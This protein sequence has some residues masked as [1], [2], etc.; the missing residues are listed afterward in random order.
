MV[1]AVALVSSGLAGCWPVP[2]QNADRTGENA[3]ESAISPADV[4]TPT[5]RW[6]FPA[7]GPTGQ[8]MQDPVVSTGGVHVA[9]GCSLATVDGTA[10]RPVLA[11]GGSA[12]RGGAS[13]A[14][15]PSVND[16][17]RARDVRGAW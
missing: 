3:F 6:A 4:A 5:Q 14:G 13:V 9:S 10:T 15:R 7:A 11:G 2:G 16:R 1:G 17:E 12:G 8:P